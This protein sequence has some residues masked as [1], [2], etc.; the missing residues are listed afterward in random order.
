MGKGDRV[1]KKA[2][3]K[4]AK[5]VCREDE[6]DCGCGNRGRI[7]IRGSYGEIVLCNDCKKELIVE[8]L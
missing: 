2:T 7:S 1:M 3:F 8:L 5:F 4:M 6:H